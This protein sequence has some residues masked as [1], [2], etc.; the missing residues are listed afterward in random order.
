MTGAPP[1]LSLLQLSHWLSPVFPTGAFAYSQGLEWAIAE[2]GLR[3]GAGVAAWLGDLLAYGS[4]QS[5]AVLLSMALRPGADHAA[6]DDLARALCPTS[7]RLA[8]T[9]DQGRALACTIAAITGRDMAPRAL[10]V[11][12]GQAAGALDLPT[13]LVIALATQAAMANL[14]TVAVRFV[15]LGQTEGQAI[16]AGLGP[17]IT[18]LAAWAETATVDDLGT[19]TLG[20]DMAAMR[21]E[22]METRIYRT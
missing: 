22:T 16:L 13:R 10:P 18:T 8:E 11:A 9:L 20:A 14:V 15:P 5:D 1:I 3:D 19:A 4:A 12:L 6:L 17:A 2:G 21:H 7:E